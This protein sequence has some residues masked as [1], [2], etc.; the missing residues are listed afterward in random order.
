[1]KPMYTKSFQLNSISIPLE[2]F[3]STYT[4]KTFV[5]VENNIPTHQTTYSI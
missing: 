1:M 2:I 4:P 5:L 3:E